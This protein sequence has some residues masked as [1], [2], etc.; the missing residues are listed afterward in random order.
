MS[1]VVHLED[2]LASN[3]GN[4][5]S[6]EGRTVSTESPIVTLCPTAVVEGV[7][8]VLP[9]E[10]EAVS[11]SVI[12]LNFDVFVLGGPWHAGGVKVVAPSF[13]GGSPEVHH[14][15]L[16]LVLEVRDWCSLSTAYLPAVNAPSDVLRCPSNH[17]CVPIVTRLE[18]GSIAVVLRLIFADD[19]H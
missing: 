6:P 9:M 5:F 1:G 11:S 16:R 14:K 13:E 15:L 4:L 19:V 17:V 8:V 3:D 7:K 10:I 2:K 12:G 18:V